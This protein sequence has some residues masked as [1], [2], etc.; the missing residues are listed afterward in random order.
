MSLASLIVCQ[1]LLEV[2]DVIT[3]EGDGN[4]VRSSGGTMVTVLAIV[5][6]L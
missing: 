3:Y 2:R 6:Y 1:H 5:I 4:R